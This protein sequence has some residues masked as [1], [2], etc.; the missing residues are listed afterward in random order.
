MSAPAGLAPGLGGEASRLAGQ[1]PGL[2]AA[3][4]RQEGG[5]A[6]V[7]ARPLRI[8]LVG[9]GAIGQIVLEAIRRDAAFEVAAVVTTA[10]GAGAAAAFL[11][12]LGIEAEVG[13]ALPPSGIDLVAEAAGQEAVARHVV[14][15]L[16]RGIRGIVASVGALSV[17]G[18]AEAIEAA[19]REGG[20][21]VE[22]IAGAIGA[23]DA[24]AAARTGRLDSVRYF[25][26]K[27]PQAWRGTPAETSHDLDALAAPAVVFSGSAR[28]AAL[29]FPK[30]ANVAA[31]VAFAGLGLDRTEVQLI[32]DPAATQN[33]HVLQAEG[34]FGRLELILSNAPSARNPKTSALAAYSL[35]R[36]LGRQ[37]AP[38][39]V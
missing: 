14:P 6:A 28:E 22:M 10:R 38:L 27:P 37:A 32:A 8:A 30:N 2:A 35:V 34:E 39:C 9:C 29:R 7:P 5:P 11:R 12:G 3:A 21:Q 23:I 36:A 16:R 13:T 18:C 19:A 15:A 20:T 17:P 4:P 24:L 25:G 31:T 1:A 33:V 26:R